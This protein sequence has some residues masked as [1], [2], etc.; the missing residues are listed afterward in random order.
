MMKQS[1]N[2]L[3]V[4]TVSDRSF[5]GDR[6]DESGPLLVEWGRSN[7][8]VTGE[9]LVVPDDIDL[10][11]DAIIR[12]CD[13]FVSLVLTTGGT[14]CAP[15]D[16]TPEATLSVIDKTIPG[17]SET[18]RLRSMSLTPNAILSRAICGIR[19]SSL[20]INLPGSPRAAIENL[21]FIVPAIPHALSLIKGGVFDC[22]DDFSRQE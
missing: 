21:N 17:M 12:L 18:M 19:G 9:L 7:G 14:G 5:A 13:K 20:I 1:I 2:E 11:K 4:I 22:A 6:P 8:Y 15:R 3:G 10:I 16:V